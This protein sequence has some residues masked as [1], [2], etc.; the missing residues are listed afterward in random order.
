[1]ALNELQR[2]LVTAIESGLPLT[3]RPYR[4]IGKRV[5]LSENETICAIDGLVREGVIKRMGVVVRHHELGFHN[6][7]M[8]VWD[9]PDDR[10]DNVGEWLGSQP[11]VTLCYRRPRR[12][13]RWPYN[14]FCMI[15]SRDRDSARKRVHALRLAHALDGV[16]YAILFGTRRFKQRGARYDFDE[17]DTR[18]VELAGP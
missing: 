15:H 2:R 8:V 3:S 18:E 9:V 4:D 1:M 5:G 12:P 10:V 6:N 11:G 14:L 7:A 16:P 13:P 17:S